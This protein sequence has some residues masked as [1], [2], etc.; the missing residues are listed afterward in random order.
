M[1]E[2]FGKKAIRH[3]TDSFDISRITV[4]H[5]PGKAIRHSTDSHSTFYG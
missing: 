4:I 3:S 1:P 2:K 5:N